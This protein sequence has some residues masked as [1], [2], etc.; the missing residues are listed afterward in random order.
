VAPPSVRFLPV[1]RRAITRYSFLARSGS[2]LRRGSAFSIPLALQFSV[3]WSCANNNDN[4]IEMLNQNA[5][6]H[7]SITVGF[8]YGD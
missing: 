6:T 2:A 5:K 3:R 1:M 4:N 7:K 8:N